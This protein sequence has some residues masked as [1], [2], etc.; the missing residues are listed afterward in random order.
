MTRKIFPRLLALSLALAPAATLRAQAG[1][2]VA[3]A[4]ALVRQSRFAEALRLLM[5]YVRTHPKDG[6]AAMWVGRAYLGTDSTDLAVEWLEKATALHGNASAWMALAQAYGAQAND[7]NLFMAPFIARK[8]RN[9]LQRAAAAEPRNV[10]PRL[11]LIQFHVGTPWLYGGSRSVAVA[12]ADTLGRLSAYYGSLARAI[13]AATDNNMQAALR[14]LN[15][16]VRQY[17]DSVTPISML[18]GMYRQKRDWT[19]AWKVVDDFRRTHAGNRRILFDVGMTARA[20]ALRLGDGEQAF[21]SYLAGPIPEGS[22]PAAAA[23]YELGQLYEQ[24]GRKDLARAQYQ[25]ALR[26]DPQLVPA[27]GALKAL[28]HPAA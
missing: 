4:E 17:P 21:L 2:P 22:P 8:A 14:S 24:Q 26:M 13:L 19:S 28:E 10:N 12:Q 27:R 25:Q 16:V 6:A 5:P 11:A 20:S 9:A 1:T 7:G 3:A 18:A 15:G 23:H